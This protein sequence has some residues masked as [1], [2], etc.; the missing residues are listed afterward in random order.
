MMVVLEDDVVLVDDFHE[1]LSN[2][3]SQVPQDWGLIYLNGCFQLYGGNFG[4]HL[5]ISRG[6]LCTYGYVISRKAVNH[7]MSGHILRSDKPIDHLMDIEV[8]AGRVIAFHASPPL[9]QTLHM[10]S[11][12][13]Y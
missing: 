6:G 1:K 13:A 2:I 11:T 9:V 3:L 7:F 5:K 10:A 12:L 8:S 4:H